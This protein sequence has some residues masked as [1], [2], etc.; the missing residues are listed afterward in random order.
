ML[1]EPPD[2]I[3]IDH[4]FQPAFDWIWNRTGVPSTLVAVHA[5]SASLVFELTECF[6]AYLEDS[7]LTIDFWDGIVFLLGAF[8]VYHAAGAH[9]K[10]LSRSVKGHAQHLSYRYTFVWPRA[11]L[12]LLLLGLILPMYFVHIV[13]GDNLALGIMQILDVITWMIGMYGLIVSPPSEP[14]KM[15]DETSLAFGLN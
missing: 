12:T 3:L 8:C 6:L 9:E 13:N 2:A 11:I 10:W 15:E 14:P 5:Y 7:S 4:V 1:K